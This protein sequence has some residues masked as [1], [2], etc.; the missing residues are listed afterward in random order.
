MTNEQKAAYIVA[1]AA[2]ANAEI[3]GMQAENQQRQVL[4]HSL[5]YVE[6]DFQ[7]VPIRYGIHHNAVIAFFM[8]Y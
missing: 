7:A 5:A 8:N 1:M 4:G 2:C 3:A 6:S